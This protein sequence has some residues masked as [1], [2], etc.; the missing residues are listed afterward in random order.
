MPGVFPGI[1]RP[2]KGLE[3]SFQFLGRNADTSVGYGQDTASKPHL[4][5][6]IVRILTG[7]AQDI[8]DR[9]LQ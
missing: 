1:A 4:Y 8:L 7:V 9:Y 6:F 5:R 3:D 2:V